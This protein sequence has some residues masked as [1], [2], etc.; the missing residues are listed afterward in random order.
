MPRPVYLMTLGI[1]AMVCSELIVGGLMPQMSRDL[2]ASIPQIGYLITAFALAMA[3]GGPAL[4]L[5]VLRLRTNDALLVLFIVFFLGNALAAAAANYGTILIARLITGATAGAFFGVALSTVAQITTPELRGRATSLAL[6]GLMLGTALGLPLS[7]LIGDQFGWRSAFIAIG[8]LTVAIT[9]AT[10]LALPRVAPSEHTGGLSAE[11]IVFRN[12]RLWFIMATSTLIIGATFAAFS[13]F[14]PI[15]TNVTGFSEQIIPLLLLGYGVA[16]VAGN[17][18]VGRLALSHTISVIVGGLLLNVVFLVGFAIFAESPAA[19]IIAMI[20]IGLVGITLNPAMVTR[21]QQAGN[22]G[23]LV[24][25]AHSSFITLGVVIGSWIGGLGIDSF[26]LRAPLWV[27]AGL[28]VLALL[29]M[30]PAIMA[31]TRAAPHSPGEPSSASST[32]VVDASDG[33]AALREGTRMHHGTVPGDDGA[34]PNRARNQSAANRWE[35]RP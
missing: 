14:T 11:L 28:A 33:S 10:T 27:G 8:I 24:N 35:S 16:T 20:G 12:A 30:V 5:A 32:S 25:T 21:V 17:V 2:G 18:A 23:P 26:G 3:L 31:A 1:F 29:A 9:I 15:L 6:Q 4:T 13:Y 7:T 22:A 34:Y 19:A